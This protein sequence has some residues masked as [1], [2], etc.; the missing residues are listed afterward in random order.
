NMKSGLLFAVI[1]ALCFATHEPVSKL[2]A[3]EID[4][5]AINAIRFFVGS[6]V[7]LPF[8]VREIVKKRI[9]LTLK[10]FI[11]MGSLGVLF[12]CVS[13][14]LLQVSVKIAD[15][16]SVVAIIFSS[17][18]IMTIILSALFLGN[19][20]TTSKG[21]GILLCVIGVI[22]SADL[23]KGTNIE[24]VIMALVSAASFSIYTVLCKKY[25]TRLSGVIQ[26]GISFFIGSIILIIILLVSGIEVTGGITANNVFPLM[27]VAVVVSGIGYW[28]YFAAMRI[29]GAQT[30]AIAFLIKPIITPFATFFVNGIK[31]DSSIIIAVILV[32]VGASLAGGTAQK[33]F[34][35]NK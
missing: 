31:P 15:S 2:F 17:N 11:V 32:V 24:S 28:A 3:N 13:T 34:V 33:L 35:K 21:I 20:I 22:V 27:Y 18:S 1:T 10:D 25:M 30:A 16:P 6:L 9:R 23:S 19:K 4:P 7:L 5:Y 29:G 14:P 26:S 12:I 8:S